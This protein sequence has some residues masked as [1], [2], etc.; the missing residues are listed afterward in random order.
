MWNRHCIDAGLD[1]DTSFHFDADPEPNPDP[2]L[3]PDPTPSFAHVG[4]SEEIYIYFIHNCASLR[5][6]SQFSIVG[7]HF[8]ILLEKCSLALHLVEMDTYPDLDPTR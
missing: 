1:P 3:D 5:T 8:K 2:D 4:K 7:E 6:V